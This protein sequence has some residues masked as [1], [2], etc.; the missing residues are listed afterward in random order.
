M[1]CASSRVR[2][3]TPHSLGHL[4]EQHNVP[5]NLD[6]A[7]SVHHAS[8]QGLHGVLEKECDNALECVQPSPQ[9]KAGKGCEP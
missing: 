4:P 1:L 3:T 5:C 6:K 2:V 8:V 7:F 9:I